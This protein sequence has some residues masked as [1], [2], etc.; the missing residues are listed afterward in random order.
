MFYGY[1]PVFLRDWFYPKPKSPKVQS[2]NIAE[3]ETQQETKGDT[4]TD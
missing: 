2:I 1:F 4:L 3:L